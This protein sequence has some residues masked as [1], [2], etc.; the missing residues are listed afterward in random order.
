MSSDPPTTLDRSRAPAAGPRRSFRFPRL[1]RRTL[2]G[3]VELLLAPLPGRGL[4]QLDLICPGGAQH[5][6]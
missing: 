2:A 1:E 4:I 3:G 6:S 5:E